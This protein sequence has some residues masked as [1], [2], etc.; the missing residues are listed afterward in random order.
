VGGHSAACVTSRAVQ[1]ALN[2]PFVLYTQRSALRVSPHLPRSSSHPVFAHTG[3]KR[4]VRR[5]QERSMTA[6]RSS[7]ILLSGAEAAAVEEVR[8]LL[9]E[10]GHNVHCHRPGEPDPDDLSSYHLAI[11]EASGDPRPSL[12]WCRHLRARS[13]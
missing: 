1:K 7:R 5:V 12:A 10:A 4:I 11:L 9:H 6:V 13:V 2:A 3:A 8:R